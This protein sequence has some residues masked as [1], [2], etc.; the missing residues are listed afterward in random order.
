MVPC[1]RAVDCIAGASARRSCPFPDG[2][3]SNRLGCS[4]V[5][6]LSVGEGGTNVSHP[7]ETPIGRE[8]AA[9]VAD[10]TAAWLPASHQSLA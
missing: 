8:S 1:A 5:L 3:M 2:Q 10:L 4:L 9:P 6:R 7:T